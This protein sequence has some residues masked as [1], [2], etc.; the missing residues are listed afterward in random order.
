MKELII[1]KGNRS[2]KMIYENTLP[3]NEL[4]VSGPFGS[5]LQVASDQ[6]GIIIDISC[7]SR[8][9]AFWDLLM[10]IFRMNVYRARKIRGKSY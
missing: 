4:P 1:K 2:S 10:Y 8:S 3:S 6:N 5:G 9:H 7:G